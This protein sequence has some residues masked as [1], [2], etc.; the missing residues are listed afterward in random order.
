MFEMHSITIASGPPGSFNHPGY[1]SQAY[2]Y[3][4]EHGAFAGPH[5]SAAQQQHYRGPPAGPALPGRY[6]GEQPGMEDARFGRQQGGM[7]TGAAVG[8][9][10]AGGLLGGW[11]LSNVLDDVDTGSHF[12]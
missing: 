11:A 1:Y 6:P 8:M 10:V 4:Q 5:N 12:Y 7:G 3:T 2:M 9:G